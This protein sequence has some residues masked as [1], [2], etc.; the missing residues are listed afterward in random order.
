MLAQLRE[1]DPRRATTRTT[2]RD[3]TRLL[4]LIWADEA[5]PPAACAEARRI[6]NLQVWPHRLA[7]GFADLDDVITGGKTGTLPGI[8]NEVGVVEYPDGGKYAVA[9]FTRSTNLTKKDA[10]ADAVIGRAARLAVD[11]LRS[12]A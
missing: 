9:C 7:S 12:R 8:R 6:L 11:E 4:Q 2:P 5:A 10:A 3:I 1:V